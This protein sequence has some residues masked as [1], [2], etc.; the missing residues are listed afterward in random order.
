[1]HG[2]PPYIETRN[3]CRSAVLLKGSTAEKS[4]KPQPEPKV[5][6]TGPNFSKFPNSPHAQP[7]RSTS[8]DLTHLKHYQPNGLDC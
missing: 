5:G 8:P 2:K 7:P 1:M 3:F 6:P 4:G